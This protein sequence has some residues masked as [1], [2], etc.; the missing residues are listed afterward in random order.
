MNYG[1]LLSMLAIYLGVTVVLAVLAY[2][3]TKSSSDYL[4]GGGD[5]HPF[6]MAMAYGS[7]FI[8][9]SAIVG[10]GGAA[11]MFGMSLLWLT[12]CNIFIGIF[13]AFVVYGKRTLAMGKELGARTFPE[14]LAKR[15]DSPF[16]RKF[17]ALVII[18]GMPLYAAAVMIGAGRFLEQL[19]KVEYTF[20]I[21]LFSVIVAAYVITGGLKGVFYN[22][23]FQGTI[24]FAGMLAL[25]TITYSKLG[26]IA[27]AHKALSDLSAKVPEGL[28]AKGHLGWT[29]MPALGSEFW[30]VVVSTLVMGVGI[31]V[32]AQPQLVV[33]F[34]TVKGSR[35]LNQA[36]VIGGVFILFMTGVAFVVGALSNVY[37]H[38]TIGKISIA[39]VVDA[40][41]QKPN[42]DNIIPL[43]VGSAMPTWFAYLFMLT[44]LSAAM[45]TLSSQFHVIGTSLCHDLYNQNSLNGNRLSILVALGASIYLSL[46]LPGS[47]IAVATAIFF[48]VCAATFLPAYTAAL[49]WPRATKAG[50]IASMVAGLASSVMLMAFV[51][52]KEAT[53]LGLSNL[54][55][56]K[57]TLVG[58]P[59]VY[60][61]PI[62]FSLPLSA[63][64]LVAVSLATEKV[65]E[66]Y[67]LQKTVVNK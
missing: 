65:R 45:S 57:A 60:I 36:V 8:S 63:V 16:I 47:I 25:I 33:R 38:Q 15:Y 55:F 3:R 37:F 35:Q 17:C 59:W 13:I 42:I 58:V 62:V 26:G 31:G 34:L 6:L 29:A 7:T 28:A 30:W 56:G 23:A 5:M 21:I 39:A 27:T 22:D 48:G 11:G 19:L 52:A 46:K 54:L 2:R 14:L 67:A 64:T 20:A 4:I 53:A 40:V 49:F 1:L 12:F 18:A 43:Y 51:H 61:D 66:G 41:T 10:F 50:V 24:M 9:T 32:L 44:L